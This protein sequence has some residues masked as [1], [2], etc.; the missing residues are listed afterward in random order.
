ME[1]WTTYKQEKKEN[2]AAKTNTIK[3]LKNQTTK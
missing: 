2:I 3:N 1:D